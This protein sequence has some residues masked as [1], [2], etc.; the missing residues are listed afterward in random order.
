MDQSN[1]TAL[2]NISV[3]IA[4]LVKRLGFLSITYVSHLI[5]IELKIIFMFWTAYTFSLSGLDRCF[6]NG[7]SICKNGGSCTFDEDNSIKC[8]CP[9]THNG[10]Y[11]EN[12]ESYDF[13]FCET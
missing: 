10:V 13:I 2:M 8:L 5:Y 12:G 4:K 7:E 6:P 9:S 11:C 1:V 3:H